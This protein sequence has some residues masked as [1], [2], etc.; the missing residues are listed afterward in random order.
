MARE[1]RVKLGLE[2]GP[3][4]SKRLG[5]LCDVQLPLPKAVW[6]GAR[7]LRGGFRNGV[8]RGRTA[9]LV[10]SPR[11]DSQR[12][13]VARLAAAALSAASEQHVLPVSDAATALQKFERSF[14]QEFLCPWQDLD[15]FTEEAGTDDDGLADAAAHF[16]VSERLVV[17][18]L[19]NRGKLPR[20]RLQAG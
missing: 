12:F 13:Y 19:V 10:T 11:E 7:S 14:A 18:T 5:Q 4:P 2:S 1:L 16:G 17:S 15:A 9:V 6:T 20:S 3:I 8:T